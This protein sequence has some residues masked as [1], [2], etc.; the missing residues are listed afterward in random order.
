[1]KKKL[2]L[3]RG[4]KH[5]KTNVP[6]GKRNPLSD[7]DEIYNE[8]GKL[9][10]C[11]AKAKQRT[12]KEDFAIFEAYNDNMVIDGLAKTTR[13]RDLTSFLLLTKMISCK[14][15]DID[16]VH[17][18]K[19]VAKIM[20]NHSKNGQ[21]TGYTS[22]LKKNLKAIV[23]FI[24]TGNRNLVKHKPELE[25]LQFMVINK[26]AESLTREDLPTDAELSK[27]LAVCS[28]HSRDKAM[29]AVH[30]E[31]GTRIGELL[32][33]NIKNF[34][35][36]KY[37]G[38]IKVSGKTGI[39]S[40]RIVT[41]VHYLSRWIND[42]PEKDNPD[43]P[44]WVSIDQPWT[45]G[46]RITYGNFNKILKKR[47]RQAGIT[48]RMYSHL[49]RHAEVT[50]L[51]GTLTE[52]ESRMRHGWGSKSTMPS[53]YAHM[54][55]GDLDDKLLRHLGIKVDEV[56]EEPFKECSYCKIKYPN[57]IR[58][59]DTCSRPLD[60][61]DAIEMEK[62]AE[63]KNKAMVYEM[64]R[65]EKAADSRKLRQARNSKIIDEQQK[66]IEAL[67]AMVTKMST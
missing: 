19:I 27:L 41:S 14:W 44:M 56:K 37:G 46:N 9:A 49:F 57:E 50:K 52:A 8:T 53:R 35:I 38:M 6:R 29:I 55:Q 24:H 5:P 64:I 22:G 54:N 63:E 21:E 67:K 45:Y 3:I 42:H 16:E 62:E 59:C 23:R 60:I 39:R 20:T 30:Q 48:K 65:K 66:E 18:K 4:T 28:S 32:K 36:D 31:A 33:M 47:V 26:P 43:A 7:P 17:C 25:M 58:F 2:E 10:Y 40:I 12:S 34:V 1:M 61:N 13:H 11:I 15:K 51:A